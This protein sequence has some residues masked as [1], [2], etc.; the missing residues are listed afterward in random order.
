MLM[1]LGIGGRDGEFDFC[2]W[3]LLGL[4]CCRWFGWLLRDSEKP[5]GQFQISD[6]REKQFKGARSLCF[7]GRRELLDVARFCFVRAGGNASATRAYR[8]VL[9]RA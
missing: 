4:G 1:R 2:F 6:F 7:S 5:L 8:L 3:C 9:V